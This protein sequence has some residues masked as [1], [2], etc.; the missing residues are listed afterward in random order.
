MVIS[1]K[2]GQRLKNMPST[3]S[4]TIRT[5]A[6]IGMIVNIV[7]KGLAQWFSKM[8]DLDVYRLI[9]CADS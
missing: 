5:L 4:I 3:I 2:I 7:Q 8:Q 6:L 9:L 1:N